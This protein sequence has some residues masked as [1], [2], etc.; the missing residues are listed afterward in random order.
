MPMKSTPNPRPRPDRARFPHRGTA[1]GRGGQ[2]IVFIAMAVVI[3]LFA[4]LWMADV[5]RI[6]FVKGKAQNAGDA[7]A[8]AAARWQATSLNFIGE[9][10]LM[11]AM[12]LAAG[13]DDAVDV[14]T[15]TQLRLGFTGPM[16][17]VAAAQQA[18]KLNNIYVN[19][20]YTDFVREHAEVVRREYGGMIGGET[21]LPEPWP[22]AWA[23]YAA[24]LEAIADDGV[25]A[26][27]DNAW[28][29]SDP[30]AGHPLLDVAFYEAVAARDW[31]WFYLNQP[32]LLE[33]YTTYAWWPGLPEPDPWAMAS[34]EMLGL[35][36]TPQIHRFATMLRA[37]GVSDAAERLG[38]D[39]SLPPDADETLPETEHV[40]FYYSMGRWSTWD[41]ISPPFPVDGRV[42]REY[43][44]MGADA[45]MRVEAA[46][47][48]FSSDG[49]T[50]AEDTIL[51]TAAA[52]A[53]G[54]LE[55]EDGRM[56]PNA[57][58]LVLPA[59]RNVALIPMD[60]STAPA[61]GSF[62]LA[63]RRHCLE[64]VP[65]YLRNGPG[66]GGNCRYCRQLVTWEI[67]AFRQAG[68]AWLGTNSWQCTLRP[69]GGGGGGGGTRRA[70]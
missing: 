13:A 19:E 9:L 65:R 25:A 63:W 39:L 30:S 64:H 3:L 6:I 31:C 16:T 46:I 59:F 22:G 5:H 2:A 26:G 43:D 56:R 11:H 1:D 51:W 36:V 37:P 18:A 35:W 58:H 15:N 47:S 48:R 20:A 70:H 42:R 34:S 23:E 29:Y 14:I 10:N 53:F 33:A 7:A 28:F 57:P 52:K 21:A 60:A 69:P 24:M 4:L 50:D 54:Y 8:L 12:A 32:G 41:A 40:W 49:G 55:G 66:A 38:I 61:G 44:Y 27:V 67:P 68:A 17:G 45:V 62:N